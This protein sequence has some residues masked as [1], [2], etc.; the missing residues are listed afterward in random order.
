VAEARTDLRAEDRRQ[1]VDGNEIVPVLRGDPRSRRPTRPTPIRHISTACAASRRLSGF[2]LGRNDPSACE[3]GGFT[4][5]LAATGANR[6]T[7]IWRA[8]ER[9]P[10]SGCSPCG[11][12]YNLGFAPNEQNKISALVQEH[13]AELLK[14]WHGYFKSD[15]GSRGGQAR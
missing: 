7:S 10:S 15:N 9:P 4:R 11:L 13:Q 3:R 6:L 1:R 5:K 12:E 2:D 8:T 14:A